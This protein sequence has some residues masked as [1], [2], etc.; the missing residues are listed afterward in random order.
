MK[1]LIIRSCD[2]D[3]LLANLCFKTAVKYNIA[4]KY[5]FFHES[6]NTEKILEQNFFNDYPNVFIVDRKYCDNFGGE[7]NILTMLREINDKLPTFSNEDYVIFCDSDIIFLKNPFDILPMDCDHAGIYDV[8]IGE[9]INHVSGQM[10]I[11]KGRLW[12]KYIADGEKNY[13]SC[14]K[15]LDIYNYSIA[16]DS[17]FSVFAYEYEAIQFSY[18]LN[19]YW[20]HH[21]SKPDEFFKYLNL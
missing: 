8:K 19:E 11:I 9:E 18:K 3:I 10:N 15:I 6:E 16:D 13:A 5:I 17:V 14:K 12:N 21:K 1:I 7:D 4:D 2:R 20:L